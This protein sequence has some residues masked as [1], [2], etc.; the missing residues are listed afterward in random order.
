M[1]HIDDALK[2]CKIHKL[3]IQPLIENTIVH[4]FPGSTGHDEID[5]EIQMQYDTYIQIQIRDNGKGMSGELV[6]LFNNYDYRQDTVDT[7]IGVRNVITRMKLYY[8]SNSCFQVDSSE[9]GTIA[10]LM[11]PYEI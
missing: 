3:L 1:I 11:I 7:S 2:N 10:T 6:E 4:G 9:Q 8:G 5:I